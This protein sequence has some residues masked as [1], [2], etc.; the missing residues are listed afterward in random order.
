MKNESL[1]NWK[2]NL[3]RICKI[4]KDNG[5]DIQQIRTRK[6]TVDGK[7]VPT[8]LTDIHIDAIDIMAIIKENELDESY[9]IG[10][11][12][13]KFRNAYNET[14]G[15]LTKEERE[16][17]E[18]LGIVVKR[19]ENISPPIYRGRKLSQFHLDFIAEMLDKILNGQIN[20]KETLKLLKQAS[21]EHGETV[22]EDAGTIKRGVEMLLK[23]RPEDLKK[24]HDI[25]KK[26][27][28][29]RILLYKHNR[30][31]PEIGSYYEKE[32]EFKQFIIEH[33][34][35]LIL[36]GQITL[37]RIEQEL[38]CSRH[39]VNQIIE[40]FYIKNKDLEGLAKFEETKKKHKGLS[41]E[42]RENAKRKREEVA[43]Y[44]IVSNKEF[45]F[46]S[47]EEQ[48]LQ[49]NMKIRFERL[50][51]E[52]SETNLTT[53][54]LMSEE[55]IRNRIK[56]LMDY[57]KSKNNPSTGKEFFSDEDIRYMIFR[58]Q[59]LI[60]HTP[61]GLDKKIAV[62][63]SYDEIDEET[64]YGM[65]KTFPAIMS[66][67]TLRTKR[68]L[69]LLKKE[70]MIDAAIS[71]PAR[72]MQS[73]ALIY[74]LIQHAKERHHTTDLT[75]ISRNNI[76]MANNA[77]KRTYGVTYEQIK[78]KYPY[79][80]EDEKSQFTK[81]TIHSTEIGIATFDARLKS[82]EASRVLNEAIRNNEKEER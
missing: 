25:L 76:F 15:K 31:K 68:Q 26:N 44:K 36:S 3:R 56:T 55:V 35:P 43:N 9:P 41:R 48:E 33:Y 46:L 20:I 24:Y 4:L 32:A 17:G 53:S 77:L 18:N 50:K 62:L 28:G 16:E 2:D 49:L 22:I 37:R 27:P 67:D 38:S 29:K 69:D 81:H 75:N 72:F 7:K 59:T 60:N 40:E 42:A 5:I 1:P 82:E 14:A 34:L 10:H 21:I 73:V 65:I 51:T 54:A 45:L 57:F 8:I 64:A 13:T 61:E 70:N 66:Y 47:P 39:T 74:A 6:T 11:Y 58:F 19:K 30:K 71:K 63:T 52:L 80:A 79:I 78:A 23:D 12:I